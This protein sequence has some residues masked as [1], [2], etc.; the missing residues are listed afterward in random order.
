MRR[1]VLALGTVGLLACANC[2]AGEDLGF[3]EQDIGGSAGRRSGVGGAGGTVGTTSVGSMVATTG[4]SGDTG[5]G[6]QT[7]GGGGSA[8]VDAS[9]ST[10][11]GSSGAGGVSGSGGSGSDAA[12]DRVI[13]VTKGF[14]L[15]FK[16]DHPT[17]MADSVQSEITIRNMG[18]DTVPL[19]EMTAR[20]Y[21]VDEIGNA[22][23][24]NINYAHLSG[25][26]PYR[27][28]VGAITIQVKPWTSMMTGQ[29]DA[30][31]EIGFSAGAGSIAPADSAVIDWKYHAVDYHMVNQT[32]DY[33]FDATKTTPTQWDH[34]TILRGGN[35]VWGAPP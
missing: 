10:G 12:I 4:A 26:G 21:L 22:P 35:V 11:G 1:A 30:Y 28:L 7:V 8:D 33:S 13:P 5:F 15:L 16:T 25:S 27:D 32:N 18:T 23:Q 31:V 2:A 20:Y 19:T 3:Y 9:T 29:A 34:V 14:V 17:P 6:G 24:F